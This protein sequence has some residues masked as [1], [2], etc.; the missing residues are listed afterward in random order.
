MY[1]YDL[2][3]KNKRSNKNGIILKTHSKY[4]MNFYS[5]FYFYF[6]FIYFFLFWG[7]ISQCPKCWD[8]RYELPYLVLEISKEL[9]K[10]NNKKNS[11]LVEKVEKRT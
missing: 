7:R 8:Y 10:L 1:S 9:L 4:A 2:P 11:N 3:I 5:F 6:L